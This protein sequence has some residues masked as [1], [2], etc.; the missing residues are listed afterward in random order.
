[1][2][3]MNPLFELMHQA[4]HSLRDLAMQHKDGLACLNEQEQ[5]QLKAILEKIINCAKEE[6]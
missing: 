4:G 3:N 5:E 1:M 2:N 6:A